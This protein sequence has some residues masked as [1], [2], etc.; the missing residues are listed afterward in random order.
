MPA[1]EPAYKWRP[2]AEPK[3]AP[4]T[5]TPYPTPANRNKKKGNTGGT[6]S[7]LVASTF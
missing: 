5:D 6:K 7:A 2:P 4:A 3:A 1:S